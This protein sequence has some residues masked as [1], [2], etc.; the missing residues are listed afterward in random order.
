[1]LFRIIHQDF[2]HHQ[3]ANPIETAGN[4]KVYNLADVP[5]GWPNNGH[6]M[7]LE[8]T[9]AQLVILRSEAALPVD[10]KPLPGSAP[11]PTNEN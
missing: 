6:R 3:P 10:P 4:W 11:E 1:M 2:A 8:A 5:Y 9:E 7:A